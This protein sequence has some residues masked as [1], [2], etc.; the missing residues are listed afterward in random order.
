MSKTNET[1]KNK[2]AKNSAKQTA[3]EASASFIERNRAIL[4]GTFTGL[5]IA[6]GLSVVSNL[7]ISMVAAIGASCSFLV[8][9]LSDAF[10]QRNNKDKSKSK[11]PFDDLNFRKETY[12]IAYE[13]QL[14]NA[15]RNKK[16]NTVIAKFEKLVTEAQKEVPH[17][18]QS[19][20]NLLNVYKRGTHA[21]KRLNDIDVTALKI[22]EIENHKRKIHKSR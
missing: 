13:I 4:L 8:S 15:K 9:Y 22:K 11:E 21:L 2:T 20:I 18:E 14:A 3:N 12:K 16:N 5:T 7:S 19:A 6:V 1:L 17:S 10:Y